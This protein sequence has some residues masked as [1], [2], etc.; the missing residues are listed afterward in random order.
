MS[1]SGGLSIGDWE[2]R[3][4]DSYEKWRE[5][6]IFF[7]SLGT[8]S[9]IKPWWLGMHWIVEMI[10]GAVEGVN[11]MATRNRGKDSQREVYYRSM[12]TTLIDVADRLDRSTWMSQRRGGY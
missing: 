8:R 7:A 4:V 2:A 1:R 10:R 12:A 11:Q 3:W 9:T 6:V 5:Q